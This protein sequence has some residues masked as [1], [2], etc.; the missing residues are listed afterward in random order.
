[1]NTQRL[2][3]VQVS[4]DELVELDAT[5]RVGRLASLAI[6]DPELH[7]ALESLL[8]ADAE[9]DAHLAPVDAA[10]LLGSLNRSD[11]LG[12]AGRTISH[13][14]LHKALGAGG[15]GVVY[16]ADDTHLGRPV[17]LKF[18][19]PHYSLDA[20]AKARFL[21]E[22]QAAAALDHRNLCT[23][24]EVGTSDEGWLFMAMALCNG[25]T[26]RAKLR[27]EGPLSV[28]ET[29]EIAR[30]IAEGLQAAHAAGI[31]HRDLKPGNIMLLPDGTVR[32]LD[33]G[34]AKARDHT[35]SGSSVRFGTVSY[36]SPEQIRA[37]HLDGRADLWALG[38][39]LYE[40]LT[41]R[42][43]FRGD[44]KALI[45]DAIL[46]DQ[47]E[48]PSTH[49]PDLSKALEGLVLR[50]LEKDPAR[51]HA[52]AAELLGDLARTQIVTPSLPAFAD[53]Y[54]IEREIGS[55]GMATVY[56]ARDLKHDRDVALKVLRP[57][58]AAM[59]G[60]ERFLNEIKINAR[61]DHPHILTL[62]DSGEADGFL[63]YVM[64]F[65]R[66]ESLR[67]RLKRERELVPDEALEITRQITSALEYAHRQGIVHRDIKPQNIL[68]HEGEAV[69][70][71]FGI[72]VAVKE[73]GGNRLTESGVTL[74]TPQYMSP[75]QASGDRAIDSRTDVYSMAAV[76][77]E[78][79][80]GEPPHSGASVKTV[81]AR[82]LT[83]RPTRL[84]VIRDTVPEGVDAAV[85]KALAKLPADRYATVGDFA[86]ALATPAMPRRRS[87]RLR[88]WISMTIGGAA[89]V[90]AIAAA[91]IL[92]RQPGPP[93]RPDGVQ[94]T[95]TGN[96][97]AA[98]LSP[99]GTRIAFAEKLCDETAYCTYQVVIQDTDGS[100]RLVVTRNVALVWRTEWTRDGRF[101]AFGGSYGPA[102]WGTFLI[103]T[104]GG[105][106]RF[107]GCCGFDMLSG[108][109]VVTAVGSL[110]GDSIGWVRRITAHDGQTLDS[111]PLHD[112]RPSFDLVDVTHLTYPDR[113]LV[114]VRKGYGSAPELR[115]ID[116]R[117]VVIDRVTPGFGSLGRTF[118]IRWV[119]SRQKL[120]VSSQRALSG[121]VFD[122][123]RMNVTASR[124][125][126]DID[127]VFSGLELGDG[128]FHLSADGERLV[129][130]LGPVEGALWAIGTRRTKEGRFAATQVLSSTT[131]LRGL[132]SPA[133]DRIVIAREIRMSDG[134]PSDFSIL[135]RDGGAE[136][137]IARGV[138]NLLDF[139]WSPDGAAIM[140]LHGIGGN[141]IRLMES[142]TMGR[143][144][145]EIARL[146]QSAAI[147][148]HPLPDGAVCVIP[149]DRRSL[150]IIRRRGKGD[151]TWRAPEWIGTIWSLSLSPDT[152]SLA[153]LAWDPPADSIVVATVNIENGRFTKLGILGG[154]VIGRSRWLEDGN[155]MFDV[156]ESEG[157]YALFTTRPGG[158][159]QR[160]GDLPL[161]QASFSMSKDGRHMAA[162]NS[163]IKNDVYM[164]R[165]FGRMLRQ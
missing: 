96:A 143:R 3:E 85:T 4:F 47:P 25:E 66:G 75:E 37:G 1:V 59:L 36:M 134:R 133:G 64:P 119:A 12:L 63:Y 55:G 62:I 82:L 40:M 103:S 28:G 34:L 116:F 122:I 7:R 49:R 154:E 54:R 151:V 78:M 88:R 44:E 124:I 135:P 101:I 71:D 10:L 2:E 158:P 92:A 123:L 13:F 81:I 16:R 117:G 138:P 11:P 51:R 56:L 29:L 163:T 39:V 99:D 21:R 45:T 165:N 146:G 149:P 121:T 90:A 95:I 84:R 57:D 58:I 145:R 43:P 104:L 73:A 94:L 144:S 83:E 22:A 77:Y 118:G 46:H 18:L 157:T 108:D 164:I 26:L 107:V 114:A 67:E 53:R 155:I 8:E 41:G 128:M 33:F 27:R 9:A 142:D 32:I 109:T 79:L 65:V 69:L 125:E 70:T 17:A 150:S 111:I 68:L 137:Q 42:K 91:L 30:Q 126:P 31:V 106:P 147:Q 76:L 86:R 61:L 38:V 127:T 139:E 52:T 156:R 132:M 6:S 48:P 100:N 112:P 161:T 140:Y 15:M 97:I 24:Y 89:G 160:L 120:V 60:T 115:L 105:A 35:L 102:R 5:E 87:A 74:G 113:L 72:A 98:S 159:T 141:K 148:F 23:V 93:P 162:F 131:L 14:H 50:L 110:P 130:T 129:H 152:K 80:A 136:S 153:V 19:L 20:S